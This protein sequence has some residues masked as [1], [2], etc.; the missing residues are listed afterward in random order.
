MKKSIRQF[1]ALLCAMIICTF[2]ACQSSEKENSSGEITVCFLLGNTANMPKIKTSWIEDELSP[3]ADTGKKYSLIVL[4][5][6]P[7]VN[8]ENELSFPKK[9]LIDSENNAHILESEIAQLTS[10]IAEDPEIDILEG[11]DVARRVLSTSQDTKRLIIF[12]SGLSTT[13]VL[14]FAKNP[15]LLNTNPSEIVDKLFNSKSI[16]DLSGIDIVWFGLCDVAG[17]QEKLSNQ[18]E[19]QLENI[20]RAILESAKVNSLDIRLDVPLCGTGEDENVEYP[21]VSIVESSGILELPEDEIGFMPDQAVFVSEID[22]I[23][24]LKYYAECIMAGAGE[25][26]I[27]GSTATVGSAASSVDLSEKRA[28]AVKSILCSTYG[29]SEDCLLTFGL[30]HDNLGG[31]YEWRDNDI[32]EDGTLNEAIAKKNRKVLI[33]DAGSDEGQKFIEQWESR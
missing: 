16:P 25:Y 30:G 8:Y 10:T 6:K 33:I 24:T 19:S 26:Y 13:G 21:P 4:D 23:E 5:G 12:S 27:V 11:L 17:N 31:K 32:N 22:A 18:H 7:N 9:L 20:W 1:V 14:N 2:T 28:E 15:E 29:I 3:L